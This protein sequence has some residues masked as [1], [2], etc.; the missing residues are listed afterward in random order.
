[1]NSYLFGSAALRDLRNIWNHISA[2]NL[3]AADEVEKAIYDACE[4]IGSYA[5]GRFGTPGF[6]SATGPISPPASLSHLLDRLRSSFHAHRNHSYPSYEHGRPGYSALNLVK[7]EA[8]P[9]L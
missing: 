2:D 3:K 7:Y 8:S 9:L 6:H 5:F 4:S 1:M